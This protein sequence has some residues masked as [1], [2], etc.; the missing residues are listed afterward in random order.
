M[1]SAIAELKESLDDLEEASPKGADLDG[2][3]DALIENVELVDHIIQAVQMDTFALE[4]WPKLRPLYMS[5]V[6]PSRENLV[7]FVS[8]YNEKVAKLC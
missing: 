8:A 7:T 5:G 3:V 4:I 6:K 1:Q 2:K